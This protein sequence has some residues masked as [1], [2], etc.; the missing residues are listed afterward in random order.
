[1]TT[2]GS[3]QNFVLERCQPYVDT[4]YCII[5]LNGEAGEVAEWY[6]K[7]ILRGN[8]TGLLSKDDLKKELGDVLFYLVALAARNGWTLE[9][10]MQ[11]NCDKLQDRINKN[12]RQIV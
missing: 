1:M 8:P 11:A 7:F 10:I 3:Y 2:S 4:N 6:K 9:E 5:A 12:M